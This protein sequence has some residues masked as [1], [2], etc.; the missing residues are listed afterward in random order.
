MLKINDDVVMNTF[1]LIEYF[2]KNEFRKR[3]IFGLKIENG[4]PVRDMNSKF[5][6][7]QDQYGSFKFPPYPDGILYF[8]FQTICD[9]IATVAI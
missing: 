1:K 8:I 3:S 5:Y 6:L 7:T 4:A 2:K 9:Y